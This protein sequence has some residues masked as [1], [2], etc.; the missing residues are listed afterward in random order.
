MARRTKSGTALRL[1]GVLLLLALAVA[2]WWW[3]TMRVWSPE[4]AAYPMQGVE[5][6][7]ADGTPSFT[8]L[9]KIGVDF[10]YLDAT[11]G[12]FARDPGFSADFEGARAAKL[13]IGAV[14]RFDP[15]QPADQQAANFVTLVP[16]DGA[17]LP[18]AIALDDLADTCPVAVS[19]AAVQS[20]LTTL[21]NEIELHTGKP[22]IL[23]VSK[24]FEDRYHLATRLDRNLWLARNR[25]QPD[26]AGRPWTMW[27]AN[28]ALATEAGDRKLRWVVV[29]P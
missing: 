24:A 9:K 25:F 4:R 1:A 22:A 28:D 6:G 11:A 15:C 23:K 8:A 17:L 16:R 13:Q 20:E 3:W 12:A 21:I 29:Q 5:L 19:E 26:Y 27:T 14:H 18:P 7:S 10:A 2:A